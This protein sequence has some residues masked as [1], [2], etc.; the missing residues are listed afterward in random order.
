MDRESDR[1]GHAEPDGAGIGGRLVAGGAKS[2]QRL[3][4]A[5][6]IDR[7]VE[8]AVEEAIVRA[9]ENEAT[10]RALARIINGP[11]I[12][13]A[14]AEALRSQAVEE[15]VIE[16]VESEMVD[17]VWAKILESDETEL[18][19]QRIAE[20]P[21][22]RDAIASQGVGLITD[23]GIEIR[24]LTAR[25]DDWVEAK[26]ARLFRNR[27]PRTEKT[28][29]AG[30]F[31]RALSIGLD[32]LIVNFIVA[33]TVALVQALL[34]SFGFDSGWL[35]SDALTLT[36]GFWFVVSSLYLFSFWNLAGQ[37]PAMRFLSIRIEKDGDWRL[38]GRTAFVRLVG[39]WLSVI[40]FGLGFIGALLRPDRRAFDD[41]MAE[42][43]VFFV[44]PVLPGSPHDKMPEERRDRYERQP[45]QVV[46]E[47]EASVETE[48]SLIR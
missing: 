7:A 30:F 40:P 24:A 33:I 22:I 21:E 42:T 9:V 44:D 36:A 31:T 10:E 19:I 38:T 35:Q 34:R 46:P 39:F 37:T 20:S 8:S 45:H 27:D 47:D 4:E 25:L 15:A 43:A 18:L 48:A 3:A 1:K 41:R 23:I 11:I 6:G 29:R 28:E 14:V 12:T 32:A 26:L 2:A 17:R 16:T 5:A 13:Q